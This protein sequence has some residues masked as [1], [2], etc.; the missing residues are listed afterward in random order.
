VSVRRACVAR[1]AA[2]VVH[3][4]DAALPLTT[5]HRVSP[6]SAPL[7][8]AAHPQVKAL[9]CEPGLAATELQKTSVKNEG[10]TVFEARLIY[11]LYQSA[12]DGALPALE[13]CFAPAARSGDFYAPKSGLYGPPV[14]VATAGVFAKPKGERASADVPS[15]ALLWETAQAAVGAFPV[16]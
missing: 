4:D 12:Q 8:P 5:Q 13:A 3:D 7:R 9:A 1:S 14:A 6:P 11:Y 16:K 15:R 10:M 2:V